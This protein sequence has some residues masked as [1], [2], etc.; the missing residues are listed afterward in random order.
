MIIKNLSKYDVET[1]EPYLTKD[2]IGNY[3]ILQDEMITYEQ[4]GLGGNLIYQNENLIDPKP[5]PE[6][7]FQMMLKG[8]Y[9]KEWPF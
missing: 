9:R 1:S 7:I 2:V 3:V 6:K 5:S 4:D 8:E